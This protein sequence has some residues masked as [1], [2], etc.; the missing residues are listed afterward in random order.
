M[1]FTPISP[2]FHS[3]LLSHTNYF[4]FDIENKV[5]I[6][7]RQLLTSL[8]GFLHDLRLN[9]EEKNRLLGLVF[10]FKIGA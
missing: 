3:K 4:T 5:I 7:V 8:L 9:L 10:K 1:G 6:V 2:S